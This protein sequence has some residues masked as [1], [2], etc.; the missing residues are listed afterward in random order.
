MD[1]EDI[2]FTHANGLRCDYPTPIPQAGDYLQVNDTLPEA[3]KRFKLD[4]GPL[5]E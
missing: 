3:D 5:P 1:L 2:D 4:S